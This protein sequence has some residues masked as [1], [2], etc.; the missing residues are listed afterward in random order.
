MELDNHF[1]PSNRHGDNFWYFPRII[2]QKGIHVSIVMKTLRNCILIPKLK[3]TRILASVEIQAL[4]EIIVFTQKIKFYPFLVCFDL[5]IVQA[6]KISGPLSADYWTEGF[7]AGDSVWFRVAL[8]EIFES[9][10]SA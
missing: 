1:E 8:A 4:S 7:I 5:S 10:I 2:D 6:L 9:M 3:Q